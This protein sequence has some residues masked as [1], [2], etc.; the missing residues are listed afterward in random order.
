MSKVIDFEK[1]KKVWEL[2]LQ[3][4]RCEAIA[5]QVGVS[6]T[7]A[8]GVSVPYYDLLKMR[9]SR[10]LSYQLLI[11]AIA[12]AKDQ[13]KS[14]ADIRAYI[15]KEFPF[16]HPLLIQV[17]LAYKGKVIRKEVVQEFER[18]MKERNDIIEDTMDHPRRV[19]GIER[20]CPKCKKKYT[21]S[22]ICLECY[23]EELDVRLDPM[24]QKKTIEFEVNR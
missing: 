10:Y 17:C 5:K 2:R 20:L 22:G 23:A 24:H 8:Y 7:L 1:I 16:S 9:T 18:R 15:K 3:G 11:Y 12:I 19:I 13:G 14:E 4:L 6:T 21:R